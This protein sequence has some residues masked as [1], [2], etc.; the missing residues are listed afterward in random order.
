MKNED[1]RRA[2]DNIEPDE[3]ATRRMLNNILQYKEK[4]NGGIW[5]RAKSLRRVIPLAL[6]LVLVVGTTVSY[7]LIRKDKSD[8][9]RSEQ[10]FTGGN[11]RR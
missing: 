11:G 9:T 3:F 7:Q 6:V 10:R 4:R 2:L 5:M 1:I 8:Y